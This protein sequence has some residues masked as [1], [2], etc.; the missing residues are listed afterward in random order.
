M[1]SRQRYDSEVPKSILA[2]MDEVTPRK[3]VRI[4]PRQRAEAE[5]QVPS[6]KVPRRG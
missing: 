6:K 2:V 3:S 4:V 5:F 1:F